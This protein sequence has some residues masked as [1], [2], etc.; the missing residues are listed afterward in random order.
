MENP[1]LSSDPEIY[2]FGDAVLLQNASLKKRDRTKAALL[3]AGCRLLDRNLVSSLTVAEI[4]KQSGVA[5]GTFYLYFKDRPAFIT[6]LLLNFVE[7]IQAVM[8]RAAKTDPQDPA[9]T[10]TAAYYLLFEINPGLMKC[11]I[12]HMEEYPGAKE[13]FQKL[14]RDWA[15][16]VVQSAERKMKS[17]ALPQQIDSDELFRRAYALGGM[18]DQYLTA[19]LLNKDPNLGSLSTDKEAVIDTLTLIWKR[20]MEA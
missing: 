15:S 10:T 16:T 7:F 13:A 20:G 3:K 19:L 9:R 18:L 8:Q 5:H 4:C 12:N 1:L 14:N 2:D 17:T 6:E 11:L